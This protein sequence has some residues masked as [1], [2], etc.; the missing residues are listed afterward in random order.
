MTERELQQ[1]L[2]ETTGFQ[3]RQRIFKQLWRL[4]QQQEAQMEETNSSSKLELS[5]SA[6]CVASS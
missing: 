2:K 5:H 1:T 3:Q 4:R 6:T